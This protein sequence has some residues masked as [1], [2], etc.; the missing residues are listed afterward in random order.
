M[1]R[2]EHAAVAGRQVLDGVE[3][4]AARVAEE[5]DV[6]AAPVAAHC[7]GAVLDDLEAMPMSNGQ[8]AVHV[9]GNA[10]EVDQA[11]CL[12]LGTDEGLNGLGDRS[13]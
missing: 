12:G 9:A 10:H 4:E 1:T 5:A 7:Q 6:L 13:A 3:G 11:D 8:N 2:Q